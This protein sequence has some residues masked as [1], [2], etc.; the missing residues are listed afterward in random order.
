MNLTPRFKI[1][2]L[3]VFFLLSLV[4]LYSFVG[5]INYFFPY[6]NE[7]SFR[8]STFKSFVE[9][10][11]V[12]K[13]PKQ[14][15][16]NSNDKLINYNTEYNLLYSVDGGLTYKVYKNESILELKP[17][18]L[19]NKVTS[20]RSK[21]SFGELY[22]VVTLLVKAEHKDG[23]H[24]T[25]P[26]QLTYYE[27]YQSN[28]PLVSLIINEEDLFDEHK[29][30]MTL[31]ENSWNDNG[32]YKEFWYKKNNFNQRGVKWVKKTYLQY[33]INN[34]FKFESK[35]GMQVSGHASRS[36]P[37]KSLKL[38]ADK[39]FGTDKIKNIFFD[40]SGIKEYS[41]L[42]LRSSGNDNKKTMFADL[43]MHNLIDN[44]KVISQ[45]GKSVNVFINGNYWGIYNL[46]ERQSK[47]Y[48][49]KKENVKVS[50]VT[51]LEKGNGTLKAGKVK[52][53]IGYINLIDS[54]SSL[55][56][57]DDDCLTFINKKISIKSFTDY[58]LIETFYGN[59]DW[60]TN[61]T[62]W[63]KAG[64]KKWKWLVV[65]LDASLAY[66][67]NNVNINHIDKVKESQTITSK[68]FNVLLMNKKFKKS[69]IIRAK[70]ILE[71]NFSNKKILKVFNE[72]KNKLEPNMNYQLNRWRGNLSIEE[73]NEN[74]NNNLEFLLKRKG[75]FLKQVE[76]L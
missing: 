58:I 38:K 71:A 46:R 25:K 72:L 40:S 13:H 56:K 47:Y 32:F 36:F 11:Y 35:L 66:L 9:S 34:E 4:T 33:F 48:I 76:E 14:G 21:P 6:N 26:K 39:R 23:I 49:A 10:K 44:T 57:I 2:Y 42:V 1:D 60:L 8:N 75:I 62:L 51:I 7:Q 55:K 18:R 50:K 22:E 12:F 27:N 43:L 20:I 28:L 65:D 61:N 45:R 64:K 17:N 37:Q 52:N 30:I 70:K 16:I 53:Q 74:C 3:I 41:A 5:N 54:L 68:L 69:F 73:W 15:K 29:G 59:T 24:F 31:G 67:N 19:I 63:Y